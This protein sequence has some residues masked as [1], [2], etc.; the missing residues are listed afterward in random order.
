MAW[1]PDRSLPVL[2]GQ[3]NAAAPGRSKASDGLVGDADH[4]A[5]ESD[6]NPESPPPPGNPDEQV[7]AAD[8]THD[9]ADGADMGVVSESIRRSRDRRV[10]YVIFN[11]RIFYGY[12]RAGLPA[13]TWTSYSGSD[14]H[15][16]HMHVS[17]N[18]VHHDETQLWAI[19]IGDMDQADKNVATAT[20]YRTDA[21]L[22]HKPSADYTISVAG[23]TVKRSE[24][25][26]LKKVIDTTAAGVAELL[27]RPPVELTDA[28]LDALALKVAA[29]IGKL[30]TVEEIAAAIGRQDAAGLR[31]QAAM[32]DAPPA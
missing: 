2:I 27:L 8:I 30:P 17:V 28:D 9:P 15:T 6:H 26:E 20:T 18:D 32:V 4:A 10:K 23:K 31:A 1:V 24:P 5:R 13:F 3:V 25:N 16:G 21:T 22:G 19:G 29:L 12:D 14:P 7:D 11:R